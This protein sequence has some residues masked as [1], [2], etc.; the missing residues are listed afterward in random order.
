VLVTRSIWRTAWKLAQATRSGT[1]FL[2][3]TTDRGCLS[4]GVIVFLA[5]SAISFRLGPP[6]P[7]V[8]DEFSY[9]LGADTF[10]HGR[11]TNPP[12]PMWVH[13]ET[14]HVLQHPT[15][16]SKYPPGQALFL[17]VGQVLFLW[18]VVGVWLGL[19]LA[20]AAL[21]WMLRGFL[22]AGWS[23]LGALLLMLRPQIVLYWGDSYWGGGL[24]LLGAALL[25]G[26]TARLWHNPQPK[27]AI[28]LV[29]GL[30][31]LANT[32]PY[33]GCWAAL[34]PL[35]F[36]LARGYSALRAGRTRGW[37]TLVIPATGLLMAGGAFMADYNLRVTG[38]PWLPPYLAYERQ[39]SFVPMFCWGHLG[40]RPAYRRQV[41]ERHEVFERYYESTVR[42]FYQTCQS[43]SRWR[44]K[45][46]QIKTD[47]FDF[48]LG[49]AL[50]VPLAFGLYRLRRGALLALLTCGL[51]L[52][53]NIAA[54]WLRPHYF[55]PGAAALCLALA[56]G[57]RRM[58]ALRLR[59]Q[60]VGPAL[61]I[62]VMLV[63]GYRDFP[64]YRRWAINE[65]F[66][67]RAWPATRARLQA[68]LAH[69]PRKVLAIVRYGP[70]HSV[71]NEWVY[72]RADID[73]SRVV[74]AR[75][76]GSANNHELLDYYADREVWLVLPDA[77]P[78]QTL[79]YPRAQLA[80][81][82]SEETPSSP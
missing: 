47:I 23:L 31:L 71:H 15:Y 30:L 46:H 39:Y 67:R 20:G 18:P 29:V 2:W 80:A 69:H 42:E 62:A 5:V 25:L 11:L 45:A 51:V 74:W 56:L 59:G 22:P 63:T 60:P 34:A 36:L 66:L 48:Y 52:A 73:A 16:A 12:H 79:P 41:F 77:R 17:A 19:A 4:V 9:L 33:E 82:T 40:A 61:V 43:P 26:A 49:P 54:V 24:P 21:Y 75:D 13:F 35:G 68:E 76:M 53:G 3:K 64:Q 65:A 55:A 14:F 70:R 6:P 1:R 50:L 58:G 72:N 37:K 7:R 81:R 28:V 27:H 32:R 44:F 78:L 38:S 57:L 10:A 8:H